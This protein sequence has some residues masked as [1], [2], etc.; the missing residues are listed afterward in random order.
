MEIRESGKNQTILEV[1][2]KGRLQ[3]NDLRDF[4][5]YLF[6]KILNRI[7]YEQQLKSLKPKLWA[8]VSV[9]IASVAVLIVA[10]DVSFRAFAQA[11]VLRFITLSFTDFGQVAANWQDYAF[12]I[13]ESLPLGAMAFLLSAC[14]A[15]IL[16]F[17]FST[18]Q[19][20]NF[21]K[22]LHGHQGPR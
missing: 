5:G 2:L 16:L 7:H 17:D 1:A 15:T 18:H 3:K 21:R 10:A 22:L 13:L 9:L 8:A 19:W 12:S 20:S 4:S 14:L 6:Y 11:P